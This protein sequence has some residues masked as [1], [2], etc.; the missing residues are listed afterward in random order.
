[1][2]KTDAEVLRDVAALVLRRRLDGRTFPAA[3]YGTADRHRRDAPEVVRQVAA[4]VRWR[5]ANLSPEGVAAVLRGKARVL[6]K[7]RHTTAAG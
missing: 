7:P 5:G 3:V 2:S 6:G 1:M 4:L